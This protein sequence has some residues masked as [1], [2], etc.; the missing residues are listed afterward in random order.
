MIMVFM[1][2]ENYGREKGF[3]SSTFSGR[4]SVGFCLFACFCF[5]FF[6]FNYHK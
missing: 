4:V 3:V 5:C 2:T 1:D 6:F